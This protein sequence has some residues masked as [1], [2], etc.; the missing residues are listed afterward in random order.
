M[1]DNRKIGELPEINGKLVKVSGELRC[2]GPA[3]AVR[4]ST[5]GLVLAGVL[6]GSVLLPWL[7]HEV[8]GPSGSLSAPFL[9][10]GNALRTGALL[11]EP[12][13]LT[14]CPLQS[15]FRV[16]FHDRRLQYT[17]HQQLEGWRWNRPGDRILDIGECPGQHLGVC[18]RA[19]RALPRSAGGPRFPVTPLL[20]LLTK[21]GS[22]PV[23]LQ[24]SPCP[25]ASS[26]PGRIQRSSTR[27]SSCGILPRG[28]R[29]SSR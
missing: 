1:L 14:V 13:L 2:S 25:W 20:L 19:P 21:P 6:L 9:V 3:G 4:S 12:Q 15:I 10:L 28:P 24:I 26:I 11:G 17:E 27:W 16:V 23:L 22:L 7:L 8:S 5:R 29:C 18:L